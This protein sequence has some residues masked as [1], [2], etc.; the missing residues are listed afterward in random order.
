MTSRP[1]ALLVDDAPREAVAACAGLDVVRVPTIAEGRLLVARERFA[2]G[3]RGG[4]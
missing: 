3:L 4:A 1:R 2:L